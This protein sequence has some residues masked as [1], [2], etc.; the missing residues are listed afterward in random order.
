MQSVDRVFSEQLYVFAISSWTGFVVL[1]ARVHEVWARL[2]SSSF[3]TY[4]VPALRYNAT[5][6]FETFPFPRPDPRTVIPE[7]EDIGERL[8]AARAKYMVN[9]DVG[10]TITYNRLKDPDHHDARIDELRRLH[11]DM[12]RAV[13]A[14]YGWSDVSVPPFCLATP[15]DHAAL[16][17]F[18]D[19]V[20]DRLFVLNAERASKE[21]A[22]GLGEA[23]AGKKGARGK[24]R[25][26]KKAPEAQA[27]LGIEEKL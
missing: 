25:K 8:Y 16:E 9:E 6:C 2:L 1:Q 24:V 12:D 19:E 23:K 4:P 26:K 11:E 22:Q 15:E 17:A 10:L 3:G 14:A 13:L 27:T 5:D 20:I 18:L 7:L 21:R